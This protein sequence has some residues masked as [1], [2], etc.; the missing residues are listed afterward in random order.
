[1][2][3]STKLL[4][5]LAHPGR[6]RG[7]L[8]SYDT[9]RSFKTSL[10]VSLYKTTAMINW[11]PYTKSSTGNIANTLQMCLL[12]EVHCLRLELSA[13]LSCTS[14]DYSNFCSIESS[15]VRRRMDSR[16]RHPVPYFVLRPVSSAFLLALK[17]Q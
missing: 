17:M 10:R 9:G 6:N 13:D 7:N 16:I 5:S 14:D 8:K 3:L 1:M 15:R 11:R 2:T 12:R 4:I